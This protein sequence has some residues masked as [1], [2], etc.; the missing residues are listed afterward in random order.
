MSYRN[1]SATQIAN[2]CDKWLKAREK[3]I[4]D[5]REV[6]IQE[7]LNSW[8]WRLFR[9]DRDKA[10]KLC[11]SEGGW[12]IANPWYRVEWRGA[13][14]AAE[15]ATLRNAAKLKGADGLIAVDVDMLD[16]LRNYL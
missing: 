16:L 1:I 15:V 8:W 14:I 7:K 4:T 10:I 5:D 11:E 6:L 12:R 9:I 13:H 3:R 2:G